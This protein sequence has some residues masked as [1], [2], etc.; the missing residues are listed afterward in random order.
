MLRIVLFSIATGL[1]RSLPLPI[2]YWVGDRIA[3]VASLVDRGRARELK[4]NLRHIAGL[5]D[6]ERAVRLLT[7]RAY[8]HMA[9]YMAEFFATPRFAPHYLAGKV[10]VTGQQHMEAALRHGCGVVLG[11]A[12]YSNW[13][14]VAS[15]IAREPRRP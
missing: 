13:E 10:H 7:R 12:H 8:R 6:D 14:L 5:G 15:M 9:T 2:L 1:A 3:D 11:T 4:D